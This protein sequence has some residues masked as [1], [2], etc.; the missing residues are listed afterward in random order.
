M[1]STPWRILLQQ[2]HA[3]LDGGTGISLTDEKHRR[4]YVSP[5]ITRMLGWTPEELCDGSN[6]AITHPDDTE[7]CRPDFEALL[8]EPGGTRTFLTRAKHKD[9]RWR[10]VETS[11]TNLL[12]DPNVRACVT[13]YREVTD[14]VTARDA[15][16]QA[17]RRFESLLSATAAVTYSCEATPP[18]GATFISENVE[19]VFGHKPRAFFDDPEFWVVNL[20]PEDRDRMLGTIPRIFEDSRG[21][22]EYRFRRGDGTYAWIHDEIVVSRDESGAPLEMIGVMLDVT[23]RHEM[24]SALRRSEANFRAVIESA[25]VGVFVHRD[26]RIIYV[27]PAL[28]SLL[29]VSRADLIGRS[30]LDITSPRMRDIAR[31]RIQSLAQREQGSSPRMEGELLR[32]DGSVVVAE[33][34]GFKLDFDGSPS[35]VVFAHDVSDRRAMLARLVASD[36]LASV[37]VLAAGVAHEINNPLAFMQTNL[38][39][40]AD[41]LAATADPELARVLADVRDGAARIQALVRDLRSF[42]RP[43]TERVAAVDLREVVDSCVRMSQNEIR[44]RANLVV[45]VGDVPPVAGSASRLGQVFLNLLINAAQSIAEGDPNANEV[46]VVAYRA[47]TGGVVVEVSDTGVGIE[48]AV[49]GHVFDPF[50]TTKPL[51]IGTGLGLSICHGIVKGLG[52]DITVES[53][54]GKGTTF[55]VV[56]PLWTGA[57]ALE[58]ER[59]LTRPPS[60]RLRI[61]VVDDERAMGDSLRLLLASDHDVTAVTSAREAL[62]RIEGGFMCDVVL[63]DLMMPGVSGMDLYDTLLRIA[64][65]LAPRVVFVTGGAFTPSSRQFL[66]RVP[67][68]RLEKPFDLDALRDVLASITT[69]T[70][71]ATP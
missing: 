34:E 51:G 12:H 67:N 64:P 18:F 31:A 53:R 16:D 71:P 66:E 43:D 47:A 41:R 10:W 46:R 70:K 36:R 22:F 24:E 54:V 62:T 25:P 13:H 32:G 30:P 9:G 63:C 20:H 40:L 6:L 48:P 15:L 35:H 38:V 49:L 57:R 2:V 14:Q 61:L 19:T 11:V 59:P 27:N 52:G 8:R 28:T 37:G 45:A 65:D 29:Q 55:R 4:I 39:L 68:P 60:R 21:T 42:A 69:D 23:S 33:I 3:V 58:S 17:R 1:D 56:L 50:F 5:A 7:R 26:D 44:S